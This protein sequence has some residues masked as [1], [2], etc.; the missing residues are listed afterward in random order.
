MKKNHVAI[1]GSGPAGLSSAFF[2]SILGRPSTIF[3][4]DHEP[5][6]LLATGIPEFRLSRVILRERIGSILKG[7]TKLRLSKRIESTEELLE[8]GFGAVFIATGAQRGRRLGIPGEDLT[9]VSDAL[10]YLRCYCLGCEEDSSLSAAG[11]HVAVIGG[12]HTAF[13]AARAAIRSE[14]A[15][16]R[17]YYRRG[18]E[19]MGAYQE[20]I[21]AA[22]R[23]GVK[24]SGL[25]LPLEAMAGP[26]GVAG[27]RMTRT[28]LSPPD[29]E[30]RRR[31][32]RVADSVFEVETDLVIKAVGQELPREPIHNKMAKSNWG[33]IAVDYR[34]G[35]SATAGI[36][37]GG[38]CVLGASSVLRAIDSGRR[39][40]LAIDK[41]LGGA[42]SL[43]LSE[44]RS[45]ER[46]FGL[47]NP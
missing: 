6:G 11:K 37:A 25:C 29:P 41:Y 8:E 42:G 20:E 12:G 23:E 24:I 30:G 32:L 10:A 5:G 7:L 36:F 35:A 33:G 39:T 17:V 18:V 26:G 38:D 28:E 22:S 46:P 34:S 4:T 13:D 21:E 45:I 14:A 16:V 19:E 1:V 44:D 31:V 3:E 2:L 43:P 15:S 47:F 27:L 40:A 9:G